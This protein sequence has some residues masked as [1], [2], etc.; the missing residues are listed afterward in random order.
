MSVYKV[1]E[2]VGTSEKSWEDA[3]QQAVAKARSSLRELRIVEVNKL[4]IKLDDQ[5]NIAA[6][7]AR[8]NVSFKY[9]S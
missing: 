4:D 8:L 2:L 7:R 5:G 1:I 9:D 3:A 6:Y